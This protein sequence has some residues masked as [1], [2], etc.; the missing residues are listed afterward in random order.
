MGVGERDGDLSPH[1]LLLA[2]NGHHLIVWS[3]RHDRPVI[4]VLYSRLAPDLLPPPARI[5][6]LLGQAASRPWHTWVWGA[7]GSAPYTPRVRYQTTVLAPARWVLPADLRQ[8][9]ADRRAWD[10]SLAAWRSHTLPT[11]PSRVIVQESDRHLPLDLTDPVQR[12]VLRRCVHRGAHALTE[13]LGGPDADELVVPG[14]HGH[15]LLEL[16]VPLTRRHHPTPARLDPRT[17]PRPPRA[18]RYL[19]GGPWLSCAL[20]IPLHLQDQALAQLHDLIDANSH[21]FDR[22][23]WLRYDTPALGPHLRIRFHGQ[24]AMLAAQLLPSVAAFAGRL[25]EEGL[26]GALYIEPYV[27]E[28]ERYGGPDA[29]TAAETV[30][31]ADSTF[32]LAALNAPAGDERLLIAA[33]SAGDIAQTLNADNPTST[34]HPGGLSRQDRHRRDRLRHRLRDDTATVATTPALGL[35]RSRRHH[36]LASYR[37]TLAEHRHEVIAL[38]ASDVVHMHC[39]RLLGPDPTAERIVRT[40]AADL[41]HRRP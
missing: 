13:P 30:F 2:T 25:E 34:L 4:P 33:S 5:L 19:P 21:C 15:H 41:L 10:T 26:A 16:V 22:W 37:D 12:E 36:A 11:P 31:A 24:P 28:I 18:G 38:C 32:A 9:A 1:D 40:L 20:S 27:Q 6:L 35:A 23:F 39:N 14:P 17:A 7:A 8:A 3:A 29:I